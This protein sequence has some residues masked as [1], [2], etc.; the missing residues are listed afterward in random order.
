V[1]T[2]YGLDVSSRDSSLSRATGYGLDALS[3]DI[4]VSRATGYGL[5]VRCRDSSVG[6]TTGYVLVVR[7]RDSAV[8]VPTVYRV[9]GRGI[10]VR[11]PVESRIFSS[12]LL[13]DQLCSDRDVKLTSHLQVM[14]RAK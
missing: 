2:G 8:S 9:D 4:S 12:P 7:S 11:I 14:P 13:A 1:A 3:L 6:T 5:D 10:G